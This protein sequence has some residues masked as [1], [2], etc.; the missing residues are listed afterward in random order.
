MNALDALNASNALNALTGWLGDWAF[1]S[2]NASNDWLG[3]CIEWVTR[4]LGVWIEWVNGSMNALN[5]WMGQCVNG[6]RVQGAK[7][8]YLLILCI[9]ACILSWVTVVMIL[10]VAIEW[11]VC[12]SDDC[13]KLKWVAPSIQ[14]CSTSTHTTVTGNGVYLKRTQKPPTTTSNIFGGSN[15]HS[16]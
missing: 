3:E 10:A 12:L 14:L 8:T 9:H 1:A 7:G 11:Q 4:W 15:L 13:W 6:L 16:H 5:W 2:M